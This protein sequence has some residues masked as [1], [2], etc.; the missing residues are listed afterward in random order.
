MVCK[1]LEVL[2]FVTDVDHLRTTNH[3]I[4]HEFDRTRPMNSTIKLDHAFDRTRPISKSDLI[5]SIAMDTNSIE[6]KWIIGFD[7]VRLNRIG[8]NRV[9]SNSTKRKH[10]SD[11]IDCSEH[12]FDRSELDTRLRSRSIESNRTLSNSTNR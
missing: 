1:R 8:F 6:A 4:L 5:K 9:R 3:S 11:R 7:Q 12:R 10:R 2:I